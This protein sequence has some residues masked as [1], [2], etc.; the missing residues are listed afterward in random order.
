MSQCAKPNQWVIHLLRNFNIYISKLVPL[1][2]TYITDL[3]MAVVVHATKPG[4]SIPITI[5]ASFSKNRTAHD[6]VT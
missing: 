5:S 2:S 4:K 6:K 3:F 1:F